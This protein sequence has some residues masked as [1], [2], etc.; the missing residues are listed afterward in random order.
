M[1][2]VVVVVAVIVT[3]ISDDDDDG[4]LRA[5][6]R[7]GCMRVCVCVCACARATGT[8]DALP[9]DRRRAVGRD[10]ECVC[11]RKK[12]MEREMRV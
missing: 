2:V 1:V 9:D 11:E 12:L 3:V 6:T 7:H 10:H 8:T 4:Y 5:R